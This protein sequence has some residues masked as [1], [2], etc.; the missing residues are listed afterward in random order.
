MSPSQRRVLHALL[1]GA[2]MTSVDRNI[3][4]IAL[5]RVIADLGA[6][7]DSSWI[8]S[9]YIFAGALVLPVAGRLLD[10]R[11]G[12]TLLLQATLLFVAGSVLCGLAPGSKVLI[13][14][15]FLQGLGG[16]AFLA[17]GAGMVGILF[18][19]RDRAA[20]AGRLGMVLAVAGVVGPIVGGVMIH[21]LGWRSVFFINL[22][23]GLAVYAVLRR[24]LQDMAPAS[25]AGMDW[26]GALTLALW[27]FPLLMLASQPDLRSM[28]VE[29]L[30]FWCACLVVSLGAFVVV[31]RHREQPLFDFSLLRNPTFLWAVLG[32][33]WLGSAS[34]ST[35]MYFPLFLVEV[36][37]QNT[38]E[39][40][41]T[42][43]AAVLGMLLGSQLLA[44]LSRAW[45]ALK[46][47]LLLGTLSVTLALAGLT[48]RLDSEASALEIAGWLFWI[49]AGLGMSVSGFPVIVQNAISRE[50][51]GTATSSV[52]FSKAL[53][54][55]LGTAFL[56]A[57]MSGT[58]TSSVP[59]SLRRSLAADGMP[60][61]EQVFEQP[62]Q[63]DIAF[64]AALHGLEAQLD[65]VA[66]GDAKALQELQKHPLLAE[67]DSTRWSTRE[68][69]EPVR[70]YLRREVEA[71]ARQA[72]ELAL[73]GYS[74]ALRRV[75]W[76]STLTGLL[77]FLLVLPLRERA[78]RLEQSG[79]P[80]SEP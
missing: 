19:P 43:T 29:K 50:R 63:S 17:L 76:G 44:R 77:A 54:A 9:A 12:K 10:I 26:W 39:A 34:T 36:M 24:S 25:R 80:S 67:Q 1:F 35:T 5:P 71:L 58:L 61:P 65:R 48:S 23:T 62:R 20:V 13:A 60:S 70:A 46:P 53:G 41:L 57:L 73:A 75:F 30:A 33:F 45:G 4:S 42:L 11:N 59:D 2:F 3:V 64:R 68:G 22:P 72:E 14:A 21:Y 15:R 56:G 31:E 51:M 38:M 37:G 8:A 47:V 32:I 52:Q 55:A 27:T 79:G 69:Q 28:G 78:G 16:G 6:T 74:Q 49:G 66:Q 18:A 7:E 40:G